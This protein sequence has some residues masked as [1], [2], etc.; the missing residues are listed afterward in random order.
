VT[1]RRLA[2]TAAA[3]AVVLAGCGSAEAEQAS[4]ACGTEVR[5]PL[6][7]SGHLIGDTP[8][9][10]PYS[11]T[12]PTSGWHAS[13]GIPLPGLYEAQLPDAAI[14]SVLEQ[15]GVVVTYAGQL[16]AD[17]RAA[18]DAAVADL[19]DVVVTPYALDGDG[20]PVTLLAWGV[21]QRCEEIDV[22]AVRAFA[23]AHGGVDLEP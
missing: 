18:A 1:T 10:V 3:V 9:P 14:V 22:A 15:G 16:D 4:A 5:P 21:M 7:A 19:G 12:P 23:D 11:S 2:A 17:G 20:P 8:P 6:Q 13:G